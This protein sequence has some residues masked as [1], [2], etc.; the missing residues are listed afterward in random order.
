MLLTRGA[1]RGNDRAWRMG[2]GT[3]TEET[4]IAREKRLDVRRSDVEEVPD[5]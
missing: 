1:T 2:K 5:A 4:S 3:A